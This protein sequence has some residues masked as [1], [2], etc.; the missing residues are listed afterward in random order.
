MTIA[1]ATIKTHALLVRLDHLVRM[2]CQAIMALMEL[3]AHRVQLALYHHGITQKRHQVASSVLLDPRDQMDPTDLPDLLDPKVY[4]VPKVQMANLVL[5]LLD[6]LEDPAQPELQDGQVR[7][8]IQARM[9]KVVPRDHL[10]PQDR[11]E[12]LDQLGQ[13]ATR[14]LLGNQEHLVQLDHQDHRDQLEE[15]E[16]RDLLDR[17][18]P[19]VRQGRMP[20]IALA[21]IVPRN[22]RPKDLTAPLT[23]LLQHDHPALINVVS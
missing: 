20:S 6:Q 1:T 21:H 11:K 16:T 5:V 7:K 18:A 19:R 15:V 8:A 22:P 9:A 4:L 2:V 3:K 13:M 14:A 12:A 10:D 17:L 23:P